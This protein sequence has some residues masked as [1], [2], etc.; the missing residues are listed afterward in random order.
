MIKKIGEYIATFS[1]LII[2]L[3]IIKQMLYYMRFNLP[4]KYFIN[5]SEIGLL[6]SDDLLLVGTFISLI[7]IGLLINPKKM[8]WVEQSVYIDKIEDQYKNLDLN[9]KRKVK[10][11]TFFQVITYVILG[12]S[13]FLI[14]GLGNDYITKMFGIVGLIASI[15][16]FILEFYKKLIYKHLSQSNFFAISILSFF[17]MFIVA[18]TG[19]DVEKVEKGKFTGTTVVTNDTTFVST[20]LSYFI[21]KTEKYLFIYNTKDS[22]TEILPAESI[23]EIRLKSR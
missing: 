12:I 15:L 22:S 21:G 20:S 9:T 19:Y 1:L 6:I 17:L 4:V 2:V 10:R 18:K 7:S 8:S 16:S 14:W 23:K 11:L 13:F 5:L 3:G